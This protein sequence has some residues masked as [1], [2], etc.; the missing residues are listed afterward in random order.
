MREL[1]PFRAAVE[2]GIPMIMTSHLLLPK[3]DPAD[4]VTLSRKFGQEILRGD[5]PLSPGLR[6]LIAAYTSK[7][8]QCPF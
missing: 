8:N 3:L 6:E 4:P 5:S 1:R 7:R 2:A